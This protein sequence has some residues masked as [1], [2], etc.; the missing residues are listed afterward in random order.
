[1]TALIGAVVGGAIGA[2]HSY[3]TTGKVTLKSVVKGALIGGAVGLTLGAGASLA[4]TGGLA[5]STAG[6]LG[7]SAVAAGTALVTAASQNGALQTAANAVV[8]NAPTVEAIKSSI[9]NLA[10]E[11]VANAQTAS[12]KVIVDSRKFS[13]YIFKDG[14][15]PGKDVVFKNLGYNINDSKL[16]TKIY[17]EQ[18]AAKYASGNY[19]L[20]K[21]DNFGQRINIEIELN[22][23]GSAKSKTSYINSGW[24]IK[25]DNSISLNTPFSGFTK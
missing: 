22:G 7:S 10:A 17:Q 12:N 21:L 2:Y 16:L 11:I 4:L 9:P 3:K 15:A 5:A 6:I 25:P 18:G 14:A 8:R 23:V 1:V 20:G 24:I 13:E 19:T